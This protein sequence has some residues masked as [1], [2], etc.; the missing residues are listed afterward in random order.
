MKA[1]VLSA[2]QGR[3]LLP[4]TTRRPKCLIAVRGGRTILDLQLEALA[5]SGVGRATV[6]VGFGAEHVER[7][8]ARN[9]SGVEVCTRFNPFFDSSDNLVTAWLAGPEMDEDFLLLNGDT[10]FEPAVVA[11]L[12]A[13]ARASVSLAVDE[14]PHYDGD[15]MKVRLGPEKRLRAIGKHLNGGTPDGEAIG[16]TYFRGAGVA[17]FRTALDRAVRDPRALRRWYPSVLAAM[18]RTRHLHAVSIRGLWWLEID[19]KP[20]LAAARAALESRPSRRPAADRPRRAAF[21]GP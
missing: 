9:G 12:V 10:L 19:S 21:S 3:R 4:L 14:K 8:L 11:R 16:L 13:G 5:A 17:A 6:M 18:A 2:G 20:D 7:H 15:D 1:I